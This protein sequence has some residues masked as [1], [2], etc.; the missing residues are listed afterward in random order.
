M[1]SNGLNDL[2]S[3]HYQTALLEAFDWDEEVLVGFNVWLI[4]SL[5]SVVHP[6]DLIGMILEAYDSNVLEIVKKMIKSEIESIQDN[7]LSRGKVYEA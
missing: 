5:N 1:D 4:E 2:G 3:I 6:S 7:R